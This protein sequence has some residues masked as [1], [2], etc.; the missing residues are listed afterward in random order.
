MTTSYEEFIETKGQM[1]AACGFEPVTMPDFLFPFQRHLVEWAVRQGRSAIFADCGLGKTAMQIV[2][3][4]NI[5]RHT[6]RSVLILTPLAVSQQTERE[7]HKFGIEAAR[8]QDGVH[9]GGIVITNYERLHHFE[10]NDFAG[11]VCDESSILK[12]FTGTRRKQITR[13]MSKMR[14]RLLCTATAAPNDYVVG[15]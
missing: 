6:G 13:F 8:C 9:N 1:N 7:A 3:A 15:S 2:W 14:Y 4:D 12:S 11:V 5:R 10:P